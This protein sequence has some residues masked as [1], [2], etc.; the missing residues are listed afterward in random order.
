MPVLHR[1]HCDGRCGKAESV[2]NIV[3][4]IIA[5]VVA[6]GL[7]AAAGLGGWFYVQ[8]TSY[9]QEQ[10]SP[11]VYAIFGFGGIIGVLRT[12]AGTVLVDSMAM[13]MQGKRVRAMAEELTG[14]PVV[15]V[16]STHYHL[17]HTHGNPAMPA[18]A[19]FVSSSATRRH[20]IA[21][22]PEFW[23]DNAPFI[24]NET[25]DRE[26]TFT[27]GN[28]SIR[29][30]LPG[31]GHTDG[32]LVVL[33]VEDRVVHTGDLVFLGRYP[34]ID[35][36]AGGS[37]RE[38]AATLDE[39]ARLDFDRAI[40]GHGPATDRQGL[41]GFRAFIDELAEAGAH[42]AAQDW[43]LDETLER[44]NLIHDAGMEDFTVPFIMH[45]DVDFVVQRSWEEATGTVTARP[46]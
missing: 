44:T 40:P 3:R 36:E 43:T 5:A 11:D 7:L 22:E 32:D 28:K 8:L 20:L 34:N 38:W 24:P 10:L 33:F 16:I 17:D 6:T 13:P 4:K 37:V 26:Q 41:Q 18:D 12:D 9:T 2:G 30:L 14:Q 29:T 23:E 46:H 45:L 25:V 21:T 42:A 39:V 35:L 27:I 31:R 15:M 19:R 1:S